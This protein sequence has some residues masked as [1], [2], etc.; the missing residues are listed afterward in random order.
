MDPKRHREQVARAVEAARDEAG[1]EESA[2]ASALDVD[3]ALIVLRDRSAP[4]EQRAQAF[5][6]LQR[7]VL[8]TGAFAA[9][10]AEYLAALRDA[11]DDP[12]ESLRERVLGALAR[13]QDRSAQQRLLDGL[14]DPAK[15]LIPA[16]VA[17]PLL[18]Y[19]IKS[20]VFPLLQQLATE[21]KTPLQTRI[22]A[23]RLLA[24]DPGAAPL[25]EGMARDRDEPAALRQVATAALHA[26]DAAAARRVARD[27][28][29]ADEESA[30]MQATSLTALAMAAPQE[31]SAEE[32]ADVAAD[33]ELLRAAERLEKAATSASLRNSA[34]TFLSRRG[35]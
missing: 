4:S 12:D 34:R 21:P 11:M 7:A 31:E 5:T 29:L 20:E 15:A 8:S 22:E 24:V 16:E 6:L 27:V 19:D 30:E 32:G 10:R 9:R 25:I 2:E 14:A 1:A 35:R 13:M 3:Q 28:V 17:I 23:V 18:S 33:D 26:N